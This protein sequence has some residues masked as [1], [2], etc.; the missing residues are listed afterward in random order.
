MTTLNT[1]KP[2]ARATM[3]RLGRR[4]SIPRYAIFFHRR[5][6]NKSRGYVNGGSA[7]P[8][9]DDNSYA[10]GAFIMPPY[11]VSF[12]NALGTTRSTPSN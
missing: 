11:G 5:R 9:D 2:K 12:G 8:Q 7:C 1:S 10:K 6:Q 3:K 4:A